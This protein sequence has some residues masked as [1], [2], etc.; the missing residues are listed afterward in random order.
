MPGGSIKHTCFKY[1]I[2]THFKDNRTLKQILVKPKDKEPEDKKSGAIYYYYCS[3][4]DCGEKYIGETARTLGERY[5]EHLRCPLLI[6]AHNQLIGHQT[7]KDNY[8][9]IGRKGQDFTRLIKES[10]FIRVNNPIL[11]RN[12]GKFQLSHIWDRVL[13]STPGI[14]VAI[15]QGNTKH[16]PS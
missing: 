11:N 1:G 16:G 12:I 5:W 10:I 8:S 6:Q 9:I 14:K 15:T 4:I 7:T 2:R 3:A 13:F